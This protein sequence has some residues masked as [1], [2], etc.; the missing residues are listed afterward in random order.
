[1]R[2]FLLLLLVLATPASADWSFGAHLSAGNIQ[3][4]ETSGS[5]TV[6]AIPSNALTYQPAFRVAFGDP[7]HKHDGY[8]DLGTL[9][10]DE[11]G[12]TLSLVVASLNY[13]HVFVASAVGGPFANVGVGFLR[14]GSEVRTSIKPSYGAGLGYRR[15]IR[16][17]HG[18]LRVEARVDYLQGDDELGRPDLT[19]LGF[20]LG[21]DLWL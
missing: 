13:Q 3:S 5:S 1:M 18:A 14:E 6:L 20:R 4:G 9:V 16:D 15:L 12:S 2:L 11:A 10:I 19:T 8:L 21:F 17:D 7:R